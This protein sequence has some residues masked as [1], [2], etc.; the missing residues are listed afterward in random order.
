[1]GF[2][3]G[4]LSDLQRRWE[5]Q[6]AQEA[7]IA[8]EQRLAAIRSAERAEDNELATG[9]IKLTDSLERSRQEDT[10]A[11]AIA[12]SDKQNAAQLARDRANDA[13]A[14][15][16]LAI[17]EGG[18]NAR[19]GSSLAESR[20]VREAVVP[21]HMKER[22]FIDPKTNIT[23]PKPEGVSD[24]EFVKQ[25]QLRHKRNIVPYSPGLMG[26]PLDPLTTP[27]A[28]AQPAAAKPK[29]PFAGYGATLV[30]Q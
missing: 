3:S 1:M 11:H 14:N 30:K 9:R 26:Q 21:E 22:L 23:I 25:M 16:R 20:K 17:S 10:Q 4:V 18:A 2:A 15:A 7:E 29:D 5:T 13:A 27:T 28:G 8:K 24:A 12:L 6:R 19:H